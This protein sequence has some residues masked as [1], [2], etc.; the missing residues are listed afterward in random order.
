MSADTPIGFTVGTPD[1]SSVSILKYKVVYLN[2]G[3]DYNQSTGVF[4][5]RIPG[6]YSFTATMFKTPGGRESY[7][8]FYVNNHKYMPVSSGTHDTSDNMSGSKTFVFMLKVGDRVYL[9]N[10]GGIDLT[11]QQSSFSGFLVSI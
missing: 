8:Y 7:C 10:C 3:G 9:S 1:T 6:L 11:N 4:T 5:C 2:E